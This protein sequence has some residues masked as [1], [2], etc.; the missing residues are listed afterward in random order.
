MFCL[1][2]ACLRLNQVLSYFS[3]CGQA[4]DVAEKMKARNVLLTHF[5]QRYSKLP[6]MKNETPVA[7]AFDHMEVG[8]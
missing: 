2:S 7:V 1:I 6:V 5:S 3:T 8:T 4:L